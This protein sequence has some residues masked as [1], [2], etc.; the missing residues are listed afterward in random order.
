MGVATA[1]DSLAPTYDSAL[2]SARWVRDRLWE[3]IRVIFPPGSRVL[4]VTAGTGLDAV[5]LAECGVQVIA[6]DIAPGMLG[7]LRLKNPT[8]ETHVADFNKLEAD[9]GCDFDG[10]ISTFAGLST[11]RDLRPFARSAARLLRPGGILLVHMLN[12][13]P[14]LDLARQMLTLRWP[15]FVRTL[16][17]ANRGIR[18]GGVNIPHYFY[19]PLPLYRRV[20]AE[21]FELLHVS[22]QGTLRPV[23]ARWGSNLEK[24]EC[25]IADRYPFHSLGTFFALELRHR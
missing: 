2:A 4:D 8:I 21:H 16:F 12:R 11:S 9:F 7:Q 19:S 25:A 15:G 13:W 1:Y 10:I 17:L 18:L 24:I 20:F 14:L 5:H 3:R 23:G 22:G 6:C